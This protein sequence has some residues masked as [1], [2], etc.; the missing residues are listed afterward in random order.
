MWA[1]GRSTR[2]QLCASAAPGRVASVERN[3]L[4]CAALYRFSAAPFCGAPMFREPPPC[5]EPS[6]TPAISVAPPPALQDGTLWLDGRAVLHGV[7][8]GWSTVTDASAT[9]V[10]LHGAIAAAACYWE[11]PLGQIAGLRRFTSVARARPCWVTPVTG[12]S[13]NAIQPE[14]QWLLG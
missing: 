12:T 6:K 4:P 7:P 3:D 1:G 10:F 14:T 5:A 8:A 9:G 11:M 2:N 13:E